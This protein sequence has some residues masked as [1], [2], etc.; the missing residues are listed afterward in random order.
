M[1][2]ILKHRINKK[3]KLTILKHEPNSMRPNKLIKILKKKLS[4]KT[5]SIKTRVNNFFF[6]YE[7]INAKWNKLTNLNFKIY[8]LKRMNHELKL[9]NLG[10]GN[11]STESIELIN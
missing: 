6:K 8:K 5:G 10:Y 1:A 4:T 3:L 7:Y 9:T 2:T 11:S